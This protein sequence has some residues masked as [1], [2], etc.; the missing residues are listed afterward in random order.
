MIKAKLASCTQSRGFTLIEVLLGLALTI[1]LLVSAIPLGQSWL[2]SID[3]AKTQ[4]SLT[5]TFGKARTIAHI[6]E[7]QV[8]LDTPISVLCVEERAITVKR[9]T[10]GGTLCSNNN[11][12]AYSRDIPSQVSLQVKINQ[13]IKDLECICFGASG[14]STL[15]GICNQCDRPL[16]ITLKTG[17]KEIDAAAG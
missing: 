17:A 10:A 14:L 4:S 16:Y 12:T 9:I 5:A 6:N 15:N 13:Q 3:L 2:E 11:E 8:G 1:A 7:A